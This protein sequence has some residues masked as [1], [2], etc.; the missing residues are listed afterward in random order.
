MESEMRGGQNKSRAGFTLA[1]ILCVVVILGIASAV[2]VPKLGSHDDL[3]LSAAARTLTADLM[4]AQNLSISTQTMHVIVFDTTNN[5]YT[6]VKYTSPSTETTL[7]HPL[8]GLSYVQ[9]YGSTNAQM[10]KMVLT[11]A[12]F[13]GLDAAYASIHGIGFDEL[14][15]PYVYDSSKTP[16]TNE[17]ISGSI[18]L[19]CGAN[20]S[21]VTIDRYTGEI[22][23]Q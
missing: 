23:V 7:S 2:I 1:E 13:T 21:T 4:Y 9:Q 17:M 19:T 16:R 22:K 6:L 12:N 8:T 20:T 11:S 5:K 3:T 15:T 14:G 18:V 10:K